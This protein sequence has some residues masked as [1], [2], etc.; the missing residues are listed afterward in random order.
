MYLVWISTFEFKYKS[1]EKNFEIPFI[2]HWQPDL[3]FLHLLLF[4]VGPVAKQA[5]PSILACWPIR[6]V[7]PSSSSSS[8]RRHCPIPSL[9]A[10]ALLSSTRWSQATLWRISFISWPHPLRFPSPP[11]GFKAQNHCTIK[12]HWATSDRLRPTLS[13]PPPVL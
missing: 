3:F 8:H 5:H 13:S 7:T 12:A 2:F 1:A 10:T 11:C 4:R 9:R 6:L